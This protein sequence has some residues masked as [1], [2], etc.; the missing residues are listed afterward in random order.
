MIADDS[1][2]VILAALL[3]A[4]A[5]GA[6]ATIFVRPTSRL[7]HRVRPYTVISRTSLGRSPDLVSPASAAFGSSQVGKVF[8]PILQSMANRLGRAVDSSSEDA[9][10]L[11]LRNAG[12]FDHLPEN[13]RII[14]Y[15][16]RILGSA[17]V[18]AAGFGLLGFFVFGSAGGVLT[19]AFLG[20]IAAVGRRRGAVD[21]AVQ[22]RIERM[23]IEIY[24]VNQLLAMHIRVGGGVVQAVQH[25]V[26]RGTGEVIGEL[27]EALR[28]HR[29]GM[30]A[31]DTFERA[32]RLTADTN[33]A[34][35]YSLLAAAEERGSDLADALL[36]LAEDVRESR[37]EALKRAATKRRA[38]TLIPTIAILAPILIGFVAAP[39]PSFIFGNV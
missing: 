29:N 39:L 19:F 8:G 18:G 3:S 28:L 23:R 27:A 37:R 21:R 1:G 20:F 2:R 9:L 10:L 32:A 24:T 16:L 38:A 4:I 34:R 36:A 7:A 26:S 22:E 11:K 25:L 30:P 5:V 35:T 12:M 31:G 13:Q 14:E 15:R 33:S 6:L 17:A